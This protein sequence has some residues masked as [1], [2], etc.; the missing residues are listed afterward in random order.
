MPVL[1]RTLHGLHVQPLFS[2]RPLSRAGVFHCT[3]GS[4]ALVARGRCWEDHRMAAYSSWT[5]LGV[6]YSYV[7]LSPTL[8]RER[9]RVPCVQVPPPL[10]FQRRCP[11]FCSILFIPFV[12]GSYLVHQP[13]GQHLNRRKGWKGGTHPLEN[14]GHRYLLSKDIDSD[15]KDLDRNRT[16]RPREETP[17]KGRGR[18][19]CL[20]SSPLGAFPSWR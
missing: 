10:S 1:V 2:T 13:R 14:P 20:P 9:G 15:R 11:S 18:A 17:S 6:V 8:D 16:L 7:A 3:V 5:S 4:D 12:C 19:S